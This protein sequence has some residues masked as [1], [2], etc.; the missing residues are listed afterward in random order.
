MI[1]PDSRRLKNT[2]ATSV[3]NAAYDPRKLVAFHTAVILVVSL[4]ALLLDFLLQEKIGDTSGLSGVGLRSVLTTVQKLLR[5]VQ[6]VVLP[7]WQM[8]W[9]FAAIKIARGKRADKD[10]LKEGF[11][12]FAPLLRLTLV[13]SLIFIALG[14]AA[15]YTASV[16]VLMLPAAEP[17]TDTMMETM[18][19]DVLNMTEAELYAM[20]QPVAVPLML[21]SAV[22]SLGLMLP[23]FYFLRFAEY[24]LL[25]GEKIGAFAMLRKSFKMMRGNL[26]YMVRLDL[27]FW[28]FYL[29]T[30]L[31]SVLG[32]LD[33]LLPAAG[34][35]LPWSEEISYFLSFLLAAVAQFVLYYFCKAKVDVT[36]AH[37]YLSL[38]PKK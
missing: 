13:K 15:A 26:W 20:I 2:A 27:S 5:L 9:L 29:L 33:V 7:F 22:L 10:D 16:I 34:V 35:V 25:D 23:A 6:I 11:R 30:V 36:Y 24:C 12:R 8:G 21:A 37:A 18:S 14:F 4:V 17:I 1:L 38:L 31:V 3:K 32:W 28:W 19:T